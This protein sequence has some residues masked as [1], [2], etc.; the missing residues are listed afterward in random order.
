MV[1]NI[2]I[3][4][5]FMFPPFQYLNPQWSQICYSVKFIHKYSKRM[6]KNRHLKYFVSLK[7][8]FFGRS[9]LNVLGIFCRL[10]FYQNP[11]ED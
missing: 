5:F 7:L 6:F 10:H 4:T 8:L 3:A 1:H 11:Q 2:S 9:G